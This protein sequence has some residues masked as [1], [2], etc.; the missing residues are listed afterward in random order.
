VESYK[1]SPNKQKRNAAT[2]IMK[3]NDQ[4]INQRMAREIK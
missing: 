2:V 4:T 3:K 1:R